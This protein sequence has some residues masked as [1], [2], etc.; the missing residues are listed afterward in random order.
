MSDKPVNLNR[1]RKLRDLAERKAKADANAIKHGRTKGQRVL[2]ATR[3][4]RARTVLDR[5]R[6]EDE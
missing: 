2:D 1:A 6:I 4:A 5:H 3:N